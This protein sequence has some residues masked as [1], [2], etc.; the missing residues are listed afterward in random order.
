MATAKVGLLYLLNKPLL[1]NAAAQRALRQWYTH[2]YIRDL[3]SLN[4]AS[5]E[6]KR[7]Y[8]YQSVDPD[9]TGPGGFVSLCPISDFRSLR[10]HVVPD[11]L[12]LRRTIPPRTSKSVV[13]EASKLFTLPRRPIKRKQREKDPR[14]GGAHLRALALETPP[15]D[16]PNAVFID[17]G[18]EPGLDQM[19]D[20]YRNFLPPD[21]PFDPDTVDYQNAPDY[22]PDQDSNCVLEP[23]SESSEEHY[24]DNKPTLFDG[25]VPPEGLPLQ[26]AMEIEPRLYERFMTS[27]DPQW[28]NNPLAS[29]LNPNANTFPLKALAPCL[30]ITH[31]PPRSELTPAENEASFLRNFNRYPF[32]TDAREH[33]R[34]AGYKPDGADHHARW[35]LV[36]EFDP[37]SS[38]FAKNVDADWFEMKKQ[39]A[40]AWWGRQGYPGAKL[41]F[42][43]LVVEFGGD[44]KAR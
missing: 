4:L 3:L 6:V 41:D 33:R 28:G 20:P 32:L 40:K 35:L 5:P 10:T 25:P 38:D 19:D 39:E 34:F 30:F 1:R 14:E 17:F 22:D 18:P 27:D 36:Q 9:V 2:T 31:I 44:G 8:A 12:S 15:E 13:K 26:K 23:P 16:D 37:L 29:L 24:M 7:V 21:T 43:R 11:V 42:F